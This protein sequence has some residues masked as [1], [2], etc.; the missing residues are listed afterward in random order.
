MPGNGETPGSGPGASNAKR[1]IPPADSNGDRAAVT[2]DSSFGFEYAED[3]Q[4]NISADQLTGGEEEYR[5]AAYAA[6]LHYARDYRM[7]IL[8]VWWVTGGVCA[9]PAGAR[10]GNAGKHPVH[11][12]WPELAT[13][14]PE[15]AAR[16]WR[17]RDPA[18]DGGEDWLYKANIACL[19]GDEGH[20]LLDVDTADG[21]TGDMSLEVLISHH[22]ADMPHTLL[23]K[24]GSGGRGFIMTIPPGTEVRNSVSELGEFLDVRGH[25]GFGVIPPSVSGRGPYQMIADTTPAPPPG[26]LAEWLAAQQRKRQERLHALPRGDNDRPVPEELSRR[27]RAYV[28]SALESAVGRVT[29]TPHGERNNSLNRE[30]FGIA[31]RFMVA[32]LLDP[33][34]VAT[35]FKAAAESAGIFGAEVVRTIAS[36]FEG[37]QAKPR[38]GEL[39]E[40][41]F[42]AAHP[43]PK[44]EPS[45]TSAIYSFE[46]MFQLR[47]ATTGEFI[48]RSVSLEEPAVAGDI[49]DEM[50]FVI[51]RWWRAEAEAW[52]ENVAKR[53]GKIDPDK[54]E[55]GQEEADHAVIFPPDGTITNVISH[56]KASA[57]GY[58]PVVQHIRCCSDGRTRIIVDLADVSGTVVLITQ[59]GFRLADP[60]QIEGQPWFRRGGAMLPQARPQVPQDVRAALEECRFVLGLSPEQ[61]L[62]ALCGLVGAH[63]PNCDRP[64]WWLTGPPGTGKTTRGRMITGL[65]DPSTHLGTR[66]NLKRDERDARTRAMHEYIVSQDNITSF[67]QDLSDWWCRLH[68]GAAE[69]VRKLHSDNV[70]LTFSY[71]RMALA[72]S[73][74]LPAGLEPDALR[75]VLHL[76]L[77]TSDEH[78][79]ASLRWERY[80]ATKPVVLG[81]LYLVLAGVLRE[82]EAAERDELPDLPEMSDFGRYLHSADRAYDLGLYEAYVRH[83]A[84]V[85]LHAAAEDPFVSMIKRWLEALPGAEFTGTPTQFHS[86]LSEF[87]GL[88]TAEPWWPKSARVLSR[89]MTVLHRPLELSGILHT[90]GWSADHGRAVTL[91]LLEASLIHSGWAQPGEEAQDED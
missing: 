74:V 60:R 61:W 3:Y 70:M 66:L 5:R 64:G 57:T 78:L 22:G 23:Y 59:D 51:R 72:T 13:D 6:A 82:L 91:K 46:R 80:E 10:C 24:T 83:S 41:I 87:A 20:F 49:A 39:P 18:E 48:S 67:T 34:D 9:C 58:E 77:P 69:N 73:L 28:H 63:F 68:T 81:A 47:R 56:L 19:M 71:K 88:A 7:K 25:H 50:G 27:A 62:V 33:G 89:K 16:W 79:D 90:A 65:V 11:Q 30:C 86:Q 42:E 38:S 52:N 55:A 4:G 53:I 15:S 14:D 43:P 84:E 8:P 54:P 44:V 75:R 37:A 2:V 40:W 21:K 35:A 85:Q 17:P 1:S 45:I 31:S 76:D 36:A 32:G 12:G 29:E 26:W